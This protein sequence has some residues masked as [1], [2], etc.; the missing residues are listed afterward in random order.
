VI[1]R[2]RAGQRGFP[3]CGLVKAAGA[4]TGPRN[5][6][7]MKPT[8]H[9]PSSTQ[10]VLKLYIAYRAETNFVEVVPLGKR[11]CLILNM[12]FADLDDPKFLAKNFTGIGRWGNGDVE[13]DVA[14][15]A[16]M[17]YGMGLLGQP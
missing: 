1:V 11:L 16:E 13:L 4:A 3:A 5:R 7:T 12:P 10:E 8:G 6:S 15:L 9:T 14:T 2:R 17:F